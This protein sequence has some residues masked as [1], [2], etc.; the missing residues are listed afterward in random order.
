MKPG[1]PGSPL[2]RLIR[3]KNWGQNHLPAKHAKHTKLDFF[4]PYPIDNCCW[5][6]LFLLNSPGVIWNCFLNARQK[7]SIFWNPHAE[8]ICFIPSLLVIRSFLAW[9]SRIS[10]MM[11]WGLRPSLALSREWMC[12][13]LIFTLSEMSFI[14]N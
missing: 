10:S 14:L 13:T 4:L 7:L 6:E 12:G 1:T 11:E 9:R 5:R 8:L 2:R 3:T